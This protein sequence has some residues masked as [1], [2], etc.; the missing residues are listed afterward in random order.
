MATARAWG[1]SAEA[2]RASRA[3]RAAVASDETR[4]PFGVVGVHPFI[5]DD[6]AAHQ[7]YTPAQRVTA[8][9]KKPRAAKESARWEQL[10]LTVS[11]AL[12]A[13]VEAIHVMDQEADDYDLLAALQQAH[14]RYVIRACPK[15]QTVD[16]KLA[17]TAILARQPATLFREVPIAPRSVQKEVKTRGRHPARAERLATLEIRW[18]TVTLPRRQDNE[19]RD[20]TLTLQAVHVAEP[21]PP[22]GETPIEWMLFTSEAV[23]GLEDATAVV[24]HYRARWIIEEYFKALKTGCGF[25]KRQLTSLPALLRALALFIPLAWRLLVLRHLG[26]APQPRPASDVLDP[27]Q[28]QPPADPARV[29]SLPPPAPADNTRC[30]AG[31]RRPRRTHQE[32]RRTRL[33]RPRSRPHSTP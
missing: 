28:L 14:G 30:H 6:A 9:R 19:A 29:A 31:R 25:E 32:Q 4:E 24:D 18:G 7:G 20:R 33:A 10:A 1:Y 17:V 26:R 16:A 27:T 2:R 13:E 8:T 15:R 21:N 5:H 3:C 23:D 11:A 12:P 22:T